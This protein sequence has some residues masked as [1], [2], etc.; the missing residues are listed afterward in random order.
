MPPIAR[1]RPRRLEPLSGERAAFI[2][3]LLLEKAP[4]NGVMKVILILLMAIFVVS[5]A[6]ADRKVVQLTVDTNRE[7]WV[8][9]D[10]GTIWHGPAAAL[11][12]P[13]ATVERWKQIIAPP[14]K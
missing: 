2:A 4:K 8:L 14:S 12:L 5:P 6:F 1:H 9:C 11:V 10:D 7:I 13:G 3:F